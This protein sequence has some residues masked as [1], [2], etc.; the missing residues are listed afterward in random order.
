MG[1]PLNSRRIL[2]CLGECWATF[3]YVG[4]LPKAP[5]TFGSLAA[6]P[7]A[8]VTWSLPLPYAWA[9]V[10][11]TFLLGVAGA[12]VVHRKTG[13]SDHQSI[14]IDE[15]VGILVTTSVATPQHW[16]HYF[17]AF[18]LFR[19]FDIAKPWPVSWIDRKWHSPVGTMMDDLVAS[20]MSTGVLWVALRF[21]R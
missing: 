13:V 19:I 1:M 17:A 15:V 3:F 6:L 18:V 8:W 7:F 10:I 16:P 2:D 11:T 14:V 4:K 21:L 9:I 5:G 12:S 20:F